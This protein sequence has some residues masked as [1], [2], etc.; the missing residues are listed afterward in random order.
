MFRTVNGELIYQIKPY[1]DCIFNPISQE[2][3][4]MIVFQ[5]G[6]KCCIMLEMDY[7]NKYL[8]YFANVKRHSS[9]IKVR[10]NV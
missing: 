4:K 9:K 10:N 1:R 5:E 6:D 8:R 2:Y 3:E 7:Y